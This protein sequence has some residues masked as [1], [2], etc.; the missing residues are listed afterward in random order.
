[1]HAQGETFNENLQRSAKFVKRK[2]FFSFLIFISTTLIILFFFSFP[3]FFFASSLK[4]FFL[5][6]RFCYQSFRLKENLCLLAY[7]INLGMISWFLSLYSE[8]PCCCSRDADGPNRKLKRIAA[9]V[10]AAA[11]TTLCNF[12]NNPFPPF[13]YTPITE[14]LN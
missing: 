14:F 3:P 9:V 10:A 5:P 1:M 4:N 12:S 7:R 11:S 13:L 8:T 6:Q 2:L